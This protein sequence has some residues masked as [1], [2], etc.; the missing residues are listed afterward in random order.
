MTI[1]PATAEDLPA[2]QTIVTR[3]GLAAEGLDYSAW[4][5]IVLVAVRQGEVV[6][7][8]SALPGKPYAV[9]TE[10]GVLPEHQK[11]RA[12]RMLIESVELILRHLGCP[13]WAGYVG[14]TRGIDSL[15]KQWGAT[16]T[17]SGAM[18]LRRL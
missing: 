10:M 5:G 2:I 12:C 4:T 8:L 6:G 11:G 18:W 3:C 13:A 15:L 9:I 14:D 7:F 17:G 16:S 1:R